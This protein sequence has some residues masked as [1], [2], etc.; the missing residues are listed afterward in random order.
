MSKSA[1]V[2]AIPKPAKVRPVYEPLLSSVR[3]V[4]RSWRDLWSHKK[5]LLLIVAIVQI[6]AVTLSLLTGSNNSSSTSN[7]IDAYINFAA[8]FTN[9]ALLYVVSSWHHGKTV[10]GFKRAYFDSSTYVL[11]FILASAM[12]IFGLLPALF[13]LLVYAAAASA[14]STIGTTTGEQAVIIGLC[15]LIAAPTVWFLTRFLLGPVAVVAGNLDPIKSLSRSRQLSLGRFWRVLARLAILLLMILVVALI[16]AAPAY[17]LAV[18]VPAVGDW[19]TIYFEVVFALI[20]LPYISI[21]LMNLYQDLVK[22]TKQ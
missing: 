15:I 11:R 9:V 19:A 14:G 10:V 18:F 21:Y 22:T 16:V 13:A 7:N 3:L 4:G 6:P 5:V 8:V 2:A 12:V 17:F 1:T 20:I